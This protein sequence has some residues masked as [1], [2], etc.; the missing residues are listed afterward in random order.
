MIMLK[1]ILMA[2]SLLVA[3]TKRK[4]AAMKI[5]TKVLL[6]T[7]FMIVLPVSGA[8]LT[9][10]DENLNGVGFEKI[11]YKYGVT[12]YKHKTSDNIRVAAEGTIAAPPDLV[13]AVLLDY[14]SQKGNIARVSESVVLKN[15]PGWIVVY[16]HLN[17]PII[18]D[19]DFTL[20][21]TWGA[22]GENQWIVYR[23]ANSLGYEERDGIVRVP[24]HH[25]S[26][27]L[28]PLAGGKATRLRFQAQLDL[29]GWL[30][31][32]LARSNAG[33]EVP[34]LFA[35]IRKLVAAR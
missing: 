9:P 10:L 11:A 17:L 3:K 20:Y 23:T 26:W 5:R 22:E 4:G 25:G 2:R 24:F 29:A 21:V 15:G 7:V 13:R 35:S 34:D 6:W 28:V 12:V 16:Q 14:A 33:K 30:P 19:R 31:K 18:S 32:W 8:E 1:N 27:Q